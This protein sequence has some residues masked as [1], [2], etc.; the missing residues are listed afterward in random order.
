MLGTVEPGGIRTEG[1]GHVL[2]EAESG[3]E[4]EHLHAEADGEDGDVRV[5]DERAD[6]GGLVGLTHGV[7]GRRGGVRGIAE[8]LGAGVVAADEQ[9]GVEGDELPGDEG[10]FGIEDEG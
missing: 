7:H 8:R 6:Q 1:L 3:A 9:E 4:T 2:V 5:I 10:Y